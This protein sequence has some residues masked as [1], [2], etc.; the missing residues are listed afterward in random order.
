MN[1]R[2]ADYFKRRLEVKLKKKV[3][4][5]ILICNLISTNKCMSCFE[6]PTIKYPLYLCDDCFNI[7]Y[8]PKSFYFSTFNLYYNNYR[9]SEDTLELKKIALSLEL[10]DDVMYRN[11]A[12]AINRKIKRILDASIVRQRIKILSEQIIYYNEKFFETNMQTELET[13]ISIKKIILR[14]ENEIEELR[15]EMSSS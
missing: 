7:L 1:D 11:L 2:T 10:Y 8:E 6:E 15:N 4:R 9:I 5:N 14:L 3:L 13:L 12:I